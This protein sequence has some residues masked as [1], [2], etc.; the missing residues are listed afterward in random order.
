MKSS[1][2]DTSVVL[3]CGSFGCDGF[4][5]V[6]QNPNGTL[7]FGCSNFK[8]RKCGFTFNGDTTKCPTCDR[9]LK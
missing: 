4:L 8:S 9:P 5:V 1:E 7:F 2:K 6:R 3:K